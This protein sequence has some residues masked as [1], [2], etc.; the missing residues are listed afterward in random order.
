M[1]ETPGWTTRGHGATRDIRGVLLHHTAGPP[2]GVFPSRRVLIEGRPG[3]AGPIANLGLDRDGTWHLIAAGLA[4]HAGKG[5]LPWVGRDNGNFHLIGIEAESTGRGDWTAA[6]RDSYP[7]GTAA[8]LAHLSLPAHRA[9]AHKE[10]TTRKIDPAGWPGDMNGFRATVARHLTEGVTALSWNTQI[11]DHN[12][13]SR[14][15]HRWLTDAAN[16]GWNTAELL[17]ERHRS[18]WVGP[19]G[20]QSDYHDT[21]VGFLLNTDANAYET[22]RLVAELAT[23]LTATRAELAALHADVRQLAAAPTQTPATGTPPTA[24]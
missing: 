11:T 7:L 3:L 17:R 10:W 15:A 13:L 22:K 5:Y 16:N 19:N 21:P 1:V 24:V 6:Q 2:N 9:V 8:L 4:S 20:T 18:R 23:A 12:G 14:P